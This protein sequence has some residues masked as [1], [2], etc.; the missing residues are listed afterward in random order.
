MVRSIF[1]KFIVFL[2]LFLTLAQNFFAQTNVT[3]SIQ[4]HADDWQ[5]FMSSNLIEDIKDQSNKVVFITFTAGDAGRGA[6]KPNASGMPY[7]LARET[8]SVYS[9]KFAADLRDLHPDDIPKVESGIIAYKNA[10]S[11]LVQHPI[12]RYYYKNTVNYFLRLPDGDRH[13]MG[14]KMTNEVSLKKLKEGDI[15]SIT[16]I[17]NS[18]TYKNW[19]DLVRTVKQIILLE[20]EDDEQIWINCA[21]VNNRYNPNDHSDHR[22]ASL[23]VRE[24]VK[25]MN[26][27]GIASW[28]N[29][30]S[31]KRRSNLS[32]KQ[33]ES[34]AAVFAIYN[35][36][37][38]EHRYYGNFDY[39]H[40]WWLS[41]DYYKITPPTGFFTPKKVLPKD[42]TMETAVPMIVTYNNPVQIGNKIQISAEMVEKGQLEVVLIDINGQIMKSKKFQV[43]EGSNNINLSTDDFVAGIYVIRLNLNNK[44]TQSKKIVLVN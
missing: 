15:S 20:Q 24:A 17:D 6:D 32:D 27:V 23:A 4:A 19:E 8:G 12:A 10:D 33:H 28:M 34:A 25:D 36:G 39:Q 43:K 13:G 29:Y 18:T 44:Y 26:W 1:H 16:A 3:F 40:Q 9:C 41:R 35:W 30:A 2:A 31:R 37:L 11:V 42:S 7:Y 14:F 22:H 5:L 21:S 38:F